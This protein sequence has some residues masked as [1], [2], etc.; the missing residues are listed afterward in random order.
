MLVGASVEELDPAELRG[1][2][3]CNKALAQRSQQALLPACRPRLPGRQPSP[4]LSPPSPPPLGL[5]AWKGGPMQPDEQACPFLPGAHPGLR[6]HFPWDGRRPALSLPGWE[7]WRSAAG[8]SAAE[9]E[10]SALSNVV[11]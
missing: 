7:R 3:L 10:P 1:A 9:E 6:G 4:R 8:L 2:R 11:S 5:R